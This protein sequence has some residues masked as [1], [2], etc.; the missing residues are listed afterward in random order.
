MLDRP[1]TAATLDALLAM[2]KLHA[3]SADQH[4]SD[5]TTARQLKIIEWARCADEIM[6]AKEVARNLGLKL[7][8]D[9]I[10]RRMGW[11]GERSVQIILQWRRRCSGN[12]EVI[13]SGPWEDRRS[14][15]ARSAAARHSMAR[16][17][18]RDQPEVVFTELL[19]HPVAARRFFAAHPDVAERFLQEVMLP[20]PGASEAEAPDEHHIPDPARNDP[21]EPSAHSHTNP[22]TR[23]WNR[24]T[25]EEKREFVQELEGLFD[26]I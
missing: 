9:D 23:A 21:D 10:G 15:V 12:P 25:V 13:T 26:D 3:E 17:V 4:E 24:A 5:E 6:S 7:T 22:I 19:T 2:A 11:T 18:S 16:R 1:D 20:R 14:A 8:N